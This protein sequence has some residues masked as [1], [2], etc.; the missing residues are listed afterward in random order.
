MKFKQLTGIERT[1]GLNQRFLVA[2]QVLDDAPAAGGATVELPVEG[3]QVMVRA[4]D[5]EA[6][7]DA[8]TG[9]PYRVKKT[10]SGGVVE[11]HL[12]ARK[13][14]PDPFVLYVEANGPAGPVEGKIEVTVQDRGVSD[15]RYV[16]GVAVTEVGDGDMIVDAAPL[17]VPA[18]RPRRILFVGPGG[19]QVL[20]KS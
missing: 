6:F 9:K 2:V 14:G 1:V 4:E 3:Q 13:L 8:D 15:T 17:P 11:F 7:L 5:P 20:S 12:D 19:V 16:G 18:V 10:R